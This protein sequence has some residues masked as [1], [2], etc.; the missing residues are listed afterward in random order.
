VSPTGESGGV[1]AGQF[2]IMKGNKFNPLLAHESL[3]DERRFFETV[4]DY[5][6]NAGNRPGWD[7]LLKILDMFTEDSISKQDVFNLVQVFQKNT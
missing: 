1:G 3:S 6:I 7:E 5:F 4:K 2:S